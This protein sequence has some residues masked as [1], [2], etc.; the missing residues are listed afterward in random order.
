VPGKVI[1]YS[2]ENNLAT[3]DT[4][5]TEKKICEK[6]LPVPKSKIGAPYANLAKDYI[7]KIKEKL[8]REQFNAILKEFNL[9]L[10]DAKNDG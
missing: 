3:E 2:Y 1:I 5:D 7:T 6:N 9:T 4:E 8:P 10:E